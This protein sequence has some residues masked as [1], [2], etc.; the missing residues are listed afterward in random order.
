MVLV[1]KGQSAS[2]L[3]DAT[4]GL[5]RGEMKTGYALFHRYDSGARLGD[6]SNRPGLNLDKLVHVAGLDL[7]GAPADGGGLASA[8]R[9]QLFASSAGYKWEGGDTDTLTPQDDVVERDEPEILL[10]AK[11]VGLE[12]IGQTLKRG[13]A[14]DILAGGGAVGRSGRRKRS[15]GLGGGGVGIEL[16]LVEQQ[17]RGLGDGELLDLFETLDAS[18]DIPGAIALL[19]LDLLV[20][21]RADNALNLGDHFESGFIFRGRGICVE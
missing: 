21:D 9:R 15:G 19:L 5:A 1:G 18:K 16:A 2:G 14:A 12:D 17:T 7:G 8:R 4:K 3:D 13:H 10:S 20:L 11:R 6:I